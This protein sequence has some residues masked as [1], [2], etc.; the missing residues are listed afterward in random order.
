M[1][2]APTLLK[3]TTFLLSAFLCIACSVAKALPPSCTAPIVGDPT[4]LW[5]SGTNCIG[6]VTAS[7][8][9]ETQWLTN[10][11]VTIGGEVVRDINFPT[12]LEFPQ[13]SYEERIVFDS[14]HFAEA[15]DII[16]RIEATNNLGETNYAQYQ[17]R[18]YNRAY[19]LGNNEVST[20]QLQV[21]DVFA[22]STLM[23]HFSLDT[24][25]HSKAHIQSAIPTYTVFY[26]YTHGIQNGFHDCFGEVGEPEQML[27]GL[28]DVDISNPVA[29][30]TPNQPD[31]HFVFIDACSTLGDEYSSDFGV[32]QAFELY[33]L[34][35]C[36]LGWRS[37][38]SV[39]QHNVDWNTRLWSEL[40]TTHSVYDAY[41]I[42]QAGGAKLGS[43]P[44]G[45]AVGEIQGDASTKMHG[46]YGGALGTWFLQ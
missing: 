19:V 15:T 13:P 6:S 38:C 39:N 3:V 46:V 27:Y 28:P 9:V 23:N 44:G 30:K 16:V 40:S 36:I 37:L 18:A 34:N 21:D 8:R 43:G 22:Y 1:H 4:P 7:G 20:A 26:I 25:W 41:V 5:F 12:P 17:A 35:E 14:T 10:V 42:A 11:T 33:S 45:L 29:S 31:Y 32:A 24:L 2:P